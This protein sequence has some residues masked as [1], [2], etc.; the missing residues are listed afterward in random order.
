MKTERYLTIKQYAELCGVSHQAIYDRL[1]AET[2]S[3]KTEEKIAFGKTVQVIDT[4]K[5]PPAKGRK[6]TK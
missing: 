5:F 2:P 1:K 4:K 6:T 3:L